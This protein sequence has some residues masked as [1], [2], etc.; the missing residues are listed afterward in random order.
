MK[1]EMIKNGIMGLIMG[2]ALG[3]PVE[4]KSREELTRNPVKDMIGYGT[5]NQPPGT[6]SDD[7]SMALVTLESLSDDGYN[8][9]NIMKGFCKWAY[10]G[11]MTPYGKT[12]SIGNT[13]S[14]ACRKYKLNKDIR[15]CGEISE[16][17]NGNGALM[18]ILPASIYFAEDSEKIIIEKSFEV[19]AL[20]HN[21]MRSKIACA[22]YSLLLSALLKGGNLYEALANANR[23]IAPYIPKE[24]EIHFR[25][26]TNFE[27]LQL[28]RSTVKSTGYVIDTLETCLWCLFNSSDYKGAVLKAVNLGDDTDTSAAVTGGL[29]GIVFGMAHVSS[30][31]TKSLAK[32]NYIEKLIKK[33][34][35]V[36]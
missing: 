30:K 8:P 23:I 21:H 27:V 22:L 36:L 12:F 11:Y 1:N 16:R 14:I 32:L 9:E 24:E 25:R 33:F 13:T 10:E 26:I 29:A 7:S 4:F 31:W 34:I 35:E 6:W 19:S 18:R 15:T 2:D 5:Y 3:V 28:N 20:T 17:S